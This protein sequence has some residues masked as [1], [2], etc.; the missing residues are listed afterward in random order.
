MCGEGAEVGAVQGS[1]AQEG[2]VL[3]SV[4][5]PTYGRPEGLDRTLRLITG[6]SWRNLEII[7]S[8][9]ASPGP[10][11]LNVLKRWSASDKRVRVL[12]QPRNIGPHANFVQVLQAASGRL[13]M[14]AADDDEWHPDFIARCAPHAMEGVSV[15][16]PYEVLNR[17]TGERRAGVL[18]RLDGRDA[19]ADLPAFLANM[20]PTILYGLHPR[21]LLSAVFRPDRYD[22]ADCALVARL[23]LAGGVRTLDGEPLY[24]AGID[25]P[26]YR[27][28]YA[29]ADRRRLDFGPFLREMTW[30]ILSARRIPLRHRVELQRRLL[31]N[32]QSLMRH[33]EGT[34]RVVL[35]TLKE[36]LRG[37][38]TPRPADGA[39]TVAS[40][41]E[42]VSYAQ[43]G[44]D[45]IIDFIFSALLV[46]EPTYLDIGAHHPTHLSNTFFFY[47]R[48]GRGVNVE[49]DPDLF[50]AF[51]EQRP[52]DTNLNCAIALGEEGE[53]DFFC[54]DPPTLNTLSEAEARSYEAT[55]RHPI[56]AVVRVPTMSINTLLDKHFADRAPDLLTVDIE[57]LDEQVVRSLDLARHRPLVI[58]VETLSYSVDRREVKLHGVID[59]L[60]AHGYMH[61]A[62]TYIN[63][64]FVDEQRWRAGAP[65]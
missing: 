62:D 64:I 22:F 7:V 19:E 23:I 38:Q 2:E 27:I 20:Q 60:L 53:A 50:G 8:D 54:I 10:E 37:N 58:C 45:L 12:R 63:S 11:V 49:P 15:M 57:G 4:G 14:W 56:R 9:N 61:Y 35:R 39:T 48:G 17:A 25:E 3:V 52:M 24:W 31:E 13:F 36:M 34:D 47:L 30:A 18:P 28:K 41:L 6:Q 16:P 44:E 59:H 51:G 33:H 21:E 5:I 40:P 32:A 42:R 55:G 26:T 65:A 1:A 43:S 46:R 29:D